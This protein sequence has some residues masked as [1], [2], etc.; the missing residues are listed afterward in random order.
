MPRQIYR[1]NALS[2]VQWIEIL[3]KVI[4]PEPSEAVIWEDS[5]TESDAGWYPEDI[6]TGVF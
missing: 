3:M 1:Q 6:E 2:N 5:D 4:A